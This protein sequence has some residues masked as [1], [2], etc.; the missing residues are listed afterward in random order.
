[1]NEYSILLTLD[2]DQI[3]PLVH[4][5]MKGTGR[6]RTVVCVLYATRTV[7]IHVDV[8]DNSA[9]HSADQVA[10]RLQSVC[11]RSTLRVHVVQ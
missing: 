10:T 7:S 4:Y 9:D 8:T 1:M 3:A 2:A 5:I 6:K 11:S